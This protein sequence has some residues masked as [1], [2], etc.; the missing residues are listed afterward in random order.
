MDFYADTTQT[1]AF[2]RRLTALGIEPL[3]K[4]G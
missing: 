3:P 4:S 1:A 2:D